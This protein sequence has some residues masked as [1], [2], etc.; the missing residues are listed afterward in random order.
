MNSTSATVT[1]VDDATNQQNTVPPTADVITPNVFTPGQIK[2]LKKQQR[3]FMNVMKKRD[4]R[5]N[6][7]FADAKME[8]IKFVLERLNQIVYQIEVVQKALIKADLLKKEDFTAVIERDKERY[9]KAEELKAD[10]TMSDDEKKAIALE[11]DIPLDVIGLATEE[12]QKG[13]D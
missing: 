8:D 2:D 7:P 6:S 3:H 11:F 4:Q 1:P 12:S 5:W 9:A 13:N 10:T